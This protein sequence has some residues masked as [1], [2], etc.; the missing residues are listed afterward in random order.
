MNPP[1]TSGTN[2]PKKHGCFF[3]GCLTVLIL[4][5]VL[6]VATFLVARYTVRQFAAFTEKYTETTPAKLPKVEVSAED[7]EV[8]QKRVDTFRDAVEAGEKTEPLVLT[9]PDLNALIALAP[10]LAQ[11]KERVYVDLEG[12]EVKGRVSL[13]LDE[14]AKLPGLSRLRGRYLNGEGTFRVALEAGVLV[15][16]PQSLRVKDQAV[17]EQ[18]MSQLRRQNLA[19]D[20]YRQPKGAEFLSKFDTIRVEDG[21]LIITGRAPGKGAER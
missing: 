16:T 10:S 2:P 5:I 14:F 9:G 8:L 4:A 17:P 15:V 21:K 6:G 20:A 3:Y 19:Q 7:Q 18:I 13:P 1:V 11:W 12:K